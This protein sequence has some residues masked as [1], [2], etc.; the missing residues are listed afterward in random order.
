MPETEETA[1]GA[2]SWHWW[3]D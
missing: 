2:N 3:I 1:V